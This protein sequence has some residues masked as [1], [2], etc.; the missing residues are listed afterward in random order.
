MRNLAKQLAPFGISVNNLAPGVIGTDRNRER[1]ADPV[2]TQRVLDRI[3]A[4]KIGTP[5]DCAAAALLLCS[6][7]AGYLTGQTIFVDGGMSL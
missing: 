7:A 5:E 2:Y 6:D 1:L 3:P 4:H